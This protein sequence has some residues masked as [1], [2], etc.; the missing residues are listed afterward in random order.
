[1]IDCERLQGLLGASTYDQ[2]NR[3]HKGW[4]EEHLRDGAKERQDEWTG[5]IAVGNKSFLENVKARLGFR[6]KRRE[7]INVGEGYLLRESSASYKTL[8]DVENEDIDLENT[9]FW[10]CKAE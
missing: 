1:M 3:S 8:F 6:A 10:D 9:L 4:V 5:S 2:L 7:V